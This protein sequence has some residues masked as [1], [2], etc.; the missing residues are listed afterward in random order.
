MGFH[1][2]GLSQNLGWEMEI[3]TPFRALEKVAF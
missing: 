1:A 3:V 2:L